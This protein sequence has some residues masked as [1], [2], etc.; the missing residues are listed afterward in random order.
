MTITITEDHPDGWQVTCTDDEPDEVRDGCAMLTRQ[1]REGLR[2]APSSVGLRK[3]AA[4]CRDRA[5]RSQGL[6]TDRQ[7]RA[8]LALATELRLTRDDR[9][10][11]AEM[12]LK[13]DIDSWSD[14]TGDDVHRLFDA[15]NGYVLIRHLR[16][17]RG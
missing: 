10:S 6:A 5:K 11:L 9:L 8:L 2:G 16:M 15:M 14:L 7:R 3:W 13:R 1:V 17:D 12:L 4:D